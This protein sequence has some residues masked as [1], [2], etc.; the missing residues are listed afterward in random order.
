MTSSRCL[1]ARRQACGVGRAR[2]THLCSE[3]TR[4]AQSGRM[5]P[6]LG[7]DLKPYGHPATETRRPVTGGRGARLAAARRGR[8]GPVL[9][10]RSPRPAG[11]RAGAG[12][13]PGGG[14]EGGGRCS[15]FGAPGGPFGRHLPPCP[16][17]PRFPGLWLAIHRCRRSGTENKGGRDRTNVGRRS[18]RQ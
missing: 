17:H 15:P 3:R 9:C 10:G 8:R 11:S 12:H 2:S 18:H 4:F 1:A 16:L 14:G 7:F 5:L 6:G 13:V